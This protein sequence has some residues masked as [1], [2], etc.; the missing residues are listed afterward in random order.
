MSKPLPALI[1]LAYEIVRGG[2]AVD[3]VISYMR[4]GLAGLAPAECDTLENY[5][6]KAAQA[7]RGQEAPTASAPGPLRLRVY[8]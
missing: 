1:S 5:I 6:F 2:W 7:A 4:T 8:R 3:D